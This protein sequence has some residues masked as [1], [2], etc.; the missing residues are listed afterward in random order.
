MADEKVYTPSTIADQPLPQEGT[1]IPASVVSGGAG[2]YS[3]ATIPPKPMPTRRVA[4]E[5]ISVALNTKSRKIL[6]EFQFTEHG[7]IQIGKYTNGVSGDIRITPN[8]ITARDKAGLTTFALDG[9]TGDATFKG[10][11]QAG[12]FVIADETGLISLN[13]FNFGSIHIDTSPVYTPG[14]NNWHDLPNTLQEF[15]LKRTTR[16]LF[17]MSMKGLPDG[18]GTVDVQMNITGTDI[19]HTPVISILDDSTIHTIHR[20]YELTGEKIIFKLEYR[21]NI[22]STQIQVDLLTST[23]LVLG[24]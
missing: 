13:N 17:M 23:F 21:V 14:D 12:D 4:V 18:A 2:V 1:E 24:S 11:V 20:V 10:T 6:A 15:I 8:G 22:P 16:V 5:L 7:A 19:A 3:P 9:D